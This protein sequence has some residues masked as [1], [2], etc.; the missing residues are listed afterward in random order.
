MRIKQWYP[1]NKIKK[2]FCE[3]CNKN[4]TNEK[5]FKTLEPSECY[6]HRKVYCLKCWREV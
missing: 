1:D 3:K 4:V 2:W 6:P 5:H